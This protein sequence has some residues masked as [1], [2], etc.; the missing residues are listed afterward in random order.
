MKI[1]LLLG[2][3]NETKLGT[4][5]KILVINHVPEVNLGSYEAFFQSDGHDFEIFNFSS[6]ENPP[7][8]DKFNALWVMGGPMNVWEEDRYPWLIKEKLFIKSELKSQLKSLQ[9]EFIENADTFKPELLFSE[10][11]LTPR[12][13]QGNENGHQRVPWRKSRHIYLLFSRW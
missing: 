6:E 8:L 4:K 3:N 9:E 2:K 10:H 11:H 7:S 13:S 1:Y 5:I 12:H